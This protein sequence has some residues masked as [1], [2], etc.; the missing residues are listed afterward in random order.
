MAKS[1]SKLK[2]IAREYHRHPKGAPGSKGGQFAPKNKSGSDSLE[3]AFGTES[4]KDRFKDGSLTKTFQVRNGNIVLAATGKLLVPNKKLNDGE[5]ALTKGQLKGLQKQII[6]DPAISPK[7]SPKTSPK[8]PR[9]GS[10]ATKTDSPK[11]TTTVSSRAARAKVNVGAKGTILEG[12][13]LPDGFPASG[14]KT[15]KEA[16]DWLAQRFPS[17]P[18]NGFNLSGN[19]ERDN[20][21]NV[22]LITRKKNAG[23]DPDMATVAALTFTKLAEQFPDVMKNFQGFN[24]NETVDTPGVARGRRIPPGTGE[25]KYTINLSSTESKTRKLNQ[26]RTARVMAD[27][28]SVFDDKLYAIENIVIHEFGHCVDYHSAGNRGK[29][30]LASSNPLFEDMN[31]AKGISVYAAHKPVEAF[32]EAFL[33]YYTGQKMNYPMVRYVSQLANGIRKK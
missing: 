6:D 19:I 12:R 17:V 2:K 13:E 1:I 5:I 21:G 7:T 31:M 29:T 25:I 9:A 10:R 33:A 26:E 14:F 32:A 8:A 30:G 24:A 16:D 27:K 23:L 11:A 22:T 4:S 28:F 18:K 15:T 3:A 20:R